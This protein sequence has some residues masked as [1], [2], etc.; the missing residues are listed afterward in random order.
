MAS[1]RGGF[2]LLELLFA[3]AL[4]ALVAGT[5]YGS[6]FIAAKAHDS[7]TRAVESPRT[8]ALA[9]ELLAQDFDAAMPPTGVLSNEFLGTHSG[10]NS[11]SLSFISCAHV[12]REGETASDMRQITLSSEILPDDPRPVL[13]RRIT[14]NLLAS[15]TLLPRE[16]I[17]CR[18]V[19]TF[20]ARYFDGSLWQDSW[21][22]SGQDNILPSAVE[23]TLEFGIAP[24][25]G[26]LEQTYRIVRVFRIECGRDVNDTN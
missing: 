1:H 8:S 10:N 3:I 11:D 12:P 6:L 26:D 2:T 25:P 17:L 15:Q 24:R 13:V 21:D 18:N 22:S 16:Q 19:K 7:A 5:L 9:M 14:T 4:M 23:V 20:T